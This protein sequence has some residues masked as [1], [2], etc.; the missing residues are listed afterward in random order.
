MAPAPVRKFREM[1]L[2]PEAT[3]V[4]TILRPIETGDSPDLVARA[5]QGDSSSFSQLCREHE[6]RLFRQALFLCGND[7]MAED[8]VQE[9]LI[10][11]WKSI[12]RFNR[13][14]A[15]FTW[16]CS[17]LLHRYKNVLRQRRPASFSSLGHNERQRAE[18]VLTD[19]PDTGSLPSEAAELA[20]R[21]QSLKHCLDVLPT[22][23]RDVIY[24]RYYSG[25]SLE[26]IAVALDCSLG[27]VKSR[28]FHAL[29]KLRRMKGAGNL[30]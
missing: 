3:F 22:K 23:H 24:L 9:T 12:R 8:L 26:G 7:S 4:N 6:A 10:E 2:L 14:C 19:L 25:D 20:E 17:I 15:L 16:L 29:E 1:I 21:A 5:Q 13:R 27:T 11:A 30:L 28:L 18:T